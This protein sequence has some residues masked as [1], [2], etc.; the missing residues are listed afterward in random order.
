MTDW[1][2]H[3]KKSPVAHLNEHLFQQEKKAR[4][5]RKDCKQVIWL[6]EEL[7]KWAEENSLSFVK[8][9]KFNPLRKY[10]FDFAFPDPDVKIAVEYEGGLFM[11]RGGH[12][13]PAGVQRDIEKYGLAQSMGWKV[14]RLHVKNYKDV[15]SELEKFNE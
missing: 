15:I 6:N 7:S 10:Q 3:I 8:E 1:L 5:P 9:Y 14:I 13:S 12:N 4:K 2:N 11:K